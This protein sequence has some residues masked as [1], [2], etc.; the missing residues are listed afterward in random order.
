M[1]PL[2]D[3]V[4]TWK[5]THD[6]YDVGIREASYDGAYKWMFSLSTVILKSVSGCLYYVDVFVFQGKVSSH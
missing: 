5:S 6:C 3:F 1:V 2:D 4:G